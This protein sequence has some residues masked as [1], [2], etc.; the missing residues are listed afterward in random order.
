MWQRSI[1]SL[2]C[3][4]RQL[5]A[6]YLCYPK[7]ECGDDDAEVELQIARVRAHLRCCPPA[8]QPRCRRTSFCSAIELSVNV[9]DYYC[10]AL[11]ILF[12]C[13]PAH[14]VVVCCLNNSNQVPP[15]STF[16]IWID[17]LERWYRGDR[18]V[19][20]SA[21]KGRVDWVWGE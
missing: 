19:L 6:L 15:S 12:S 17:W 11:F 13:S 7:R 18:L 4:Q 10:C 16:V 20:D 2:L 9:R 8:C 14:L 21:I 5:I 1:F 3:Q